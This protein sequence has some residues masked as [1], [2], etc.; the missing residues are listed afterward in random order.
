M[1]LALVEGVGE[2]TREFRKEFSCRPMIVG[3]ETV[4]TV[5]SMV[6][7]VLVSFQLVSMPWVFL[8]WLVGSIT[9]SIASY[10]R[11]NLMWTLL[12]MFYL[13]MNLAGLMY[14]LI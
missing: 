3:C 4:G 12:S 9:L 10:Y 2:L 8:L 11:K 1:I 13:C 7:S 5:S 6:A 14:W